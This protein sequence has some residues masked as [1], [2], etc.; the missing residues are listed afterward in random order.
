MSSYIAC[1][2]HRCV[3]APSIPSSSFA[4][5][6]SSLRK[7]GSSD[8]GFSLSR[9]NAFAVGELLFFEGLQRKVTKRKQPSPIR[10]NPPNGSR[11][12]FSK[13]RPVPWKNAA[14]PVRRPPGL[15]VA[16]W[17]QIFRSNARDA[18]ALALALALAGHPIPA[19]DCQR[20][21]LKGRRPWIGAVFSRA[22]DG[23]SE[24]L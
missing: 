13:G 17:P 20:K 21:T 3:R 5:R 1:L 22:M 4:L 14:R 16:Q 11:R 2:M 6:S 9:S 8:L 7:Q 23:E 19:I 12:D 18:A 15:C 24:N 10:A